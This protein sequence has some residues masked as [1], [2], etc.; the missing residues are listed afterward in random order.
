MAPGQCM[1]C[2]DGAEY[3]GGP[4]VHTCKDTMKNPLKRRSG[5]AQAARQ[6]PAP[7]MHHRLEPRGGSQPDKEIEDQ[8]PNEKD[9]TDAIAW[10][11]SRPVGEIAEDG[12]WRPAGDPTLHDVLLELGY[13]HSP[14]T[15][16]GKRNIYRGTELVKS[17][18]TAGEVWKWL[19]KTGQWK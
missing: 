3:E 9:T 17:S 11:N 12:K 13:V 7:K 6:R 5:S 14:A 19:R 10:L 8:M 16:P 2:L 1:G 15:A 18:V 4:V